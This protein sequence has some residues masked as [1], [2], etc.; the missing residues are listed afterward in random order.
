MK[1]VS[2][3]L[4]LPFDRAFDYHFE[5]ANDVTIGDIVLV[6]F[7][8]RQVFGV[9][10]GLPEES[11]SESK[12]KSIIT[13]TNFQVKPELLSFIRF[14]ADYNIIPI[15]MVL[16]M[17]L[18][19]PKVFE[20]Q[21]QKKPKSITSCPTEKKDNVILSDEQK[22][23]FFSLKEK[24]LRGFNVSVLKGITGSGKTEVYLELI[25]EV[26]SNG[27]QVLVL[28]P[29]IL[30]TTQLI[31]RFRSRLD[32]EVFEWHS[33]ISQAKRADTWQRVYSGDIKL[34]V[35]ARSSLFLP[36]SDIGL[37]II[38]EEHESAFKQEESGCYHA[39]DMA[40]ARAKINNILIILSSATPSMETESNVR[41][42]KYSQ[43][44]LTSRYGQASLPN[45]NIIDLI[46]DKPANGSWL[47]NGLRHKI[48][49]NFTSN[50]QA[51]IYLN[52]RGYS[53]VTLCN[54]C[55][56]KVVCPNCD[57]N[58]VSHKFKEILMCHYCGFSQ[59]KNHK[60]SC[61]GSDSRFSDVG[62]G[63]ERIS[64][65]ISTILP[66]ARVIILSSDT[67]NTRSKAQEA[68]KSIINQEVDIIIGTQ[69]IIKGL[70]F[71][72]LDLVGVVDADLSL[73]TGDVRAMER[74]YQILKQVSGRA[75]RESGMGNVYLQTVEP[76][77]Y[78]IQSIKNEDWESF[79]DNELA[80]RQLANMPPFTRIVMVMISG[81]NQEQLVILLNKLV[82][83]IP[84]FDKVRF[85]GP[86]PAPLFKLKGKLRYRFIVIAEKNIN[87]QKLVK[88]WINTQIIPNNIE[89]R[90]DVDPIT[91]N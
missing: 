40:I 91:F 80:N 61:C 63:V 71:P 23:A 34:I 58:L 84:N 6:P 51:L 19:A 88:Q 17:A 11:S 14:V 13:L 83:Y 36:F 53:M 7:R 54:D 87:V 50:K 15:G 12:L 47:T 49:E 42:A 35:G 9:V 5:E 90:I 70:H 29:E 76:G 28:L 33:A 56:M 24:L 18:A 25:K 37:I 72:K 82:K 69:M 22:T 67:L 30:L 73:Y 75:G 31:D 79:I 2:V 27:K 10:T 3:L 78:L 52:R 21:K 39:R 32:F 77:S 43:V 46:K 74:T 41:E 65:E 1:V 8:N 55:R 60:C 89:V 64:E 20:P 16:K 26:I 66:E 86:T 44:T 48:I 62:P 59:S 45:I 85:L 4:P 81:K 38:D 68:I 57:F